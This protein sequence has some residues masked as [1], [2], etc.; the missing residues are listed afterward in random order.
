M[1]ERE[2][3]CT[4]PVRGRILVDAPTEPVDWLL[5]GLHGY[6]ETARRQL[7]RQ[8]A[9][10]PAGSAHAAL[11]GLHAFYTKGA[12]GAI[13]AS[14]LTSDRREQRLAEN[15]HYFAA[16]L[17]ELRATGLR[18]RRLAWAGFSQ[19]ASQAYRAWRAVGGD[20][21]VVNGGDIPPELIGDE[22]RSLPPLL[23]GR[24]VEDG[25]YSVERLGADRERLAAAGVQPELWEGA[26]GH[27]WTA[28]WSEVCRAFLAAR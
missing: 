7:D 14:W 4:V 5:V 12:H 3:A 9:A 16:A 8:R 28:A 18:W 10:A 25:A 17:E 27:A 15:R 20:A 13:G 26:D 21:L 23:I 2:L 1:S 22:M 6:G 24:G 11:E 19:G